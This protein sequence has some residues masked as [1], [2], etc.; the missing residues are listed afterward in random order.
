MPR[1]SIRPATTDQQ[2]TAHTAA[3]I[4]VYIHNKHKDIYVREL[5]AHHLCTRALGGVHAPVLAVAAADLVGV[6]VAQVHAVR[7]EVRHV[8]EGIARELH[9]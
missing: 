9:M 8:G 1:M 4:M 6:A 2:C 5:A 7:H 3:H